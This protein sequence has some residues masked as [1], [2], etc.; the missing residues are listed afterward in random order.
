MYIG[1]SGGSYIVTTDSHEATAN[2]DIGPR[3]RPN[4]MI[5]KLNIKIN[6]MIKTI[7]KG[8][9]KL[10]CAKDG[11]RILYLKDQAYLWSHAKGIGELLA[12]SRRT[13]EISH[14]IVEGNFRIYNVKREPEL[15][16][17]KHL[18]LSV[19]NGRWQGYLLLTGLPTSSKV[20]SRIVPTDE[21]ISETKS[22]NT[23][24]I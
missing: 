16:D 6:A 3:R 7:T 18:E 12:F 17:L 10:V 22:K 5:T 19:G 21:I 8:N 9:Y 20:R 23:T 24:Q 14:T 2:S 13:R 11:E 1:S 15:V 4:E